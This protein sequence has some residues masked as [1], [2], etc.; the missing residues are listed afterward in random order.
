M[1]HMYKVNYVYTTI[2][3]LHIPL[4]STNF[5]EYSKKKTAFL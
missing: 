4:K 5:G 1:S 2:Y 3:T